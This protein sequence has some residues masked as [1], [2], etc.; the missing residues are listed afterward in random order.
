MRRAV[1]TLS[2]ALMTIA[3]TAALA[4]EITRQT[5]A[6]PEDAYPHDVAA[7]PNGVVWYSGQRLGVLGRLD[8]ATGTVEQIPLG[9]G[10][11]P[12]GV[13]VGP[14]G[15]PWLTD[16]GVNAIVRVDPATRRIDRFPLPEAR[17]YV[18]L[19]TAVFDRSG[20]LW[21]TGQ[22]GVY[23]RLDPTT[24]KVKVWDAPKGRG[25]YGIA[26]TPDGGV[27]FVSLANNYLAKIDTASGAATVIEPPTKD[28][29]ARRVWSDSQ[30]R[31]WISEWSSG[32]LSRYD[33]KTQAWQSWRP[34][35]DRPRLY[36]IYVDEHDIV[37]TSDWGGH[38]ILR[39]DPASEQF[40]SFPLDRGADV[41]Q[42]LGRKGEVWIA[43]SGKD[44]VTVLRF[45]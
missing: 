19:N 10:S 22:N 6:L 26:A 31:L 36:A 42:M 2:T 24:R 15:A 1:L 40:Q 21:F 39:F 3:T 11:A 13:I 41:R 28:Q 45:E 33:P 5:Y 16:G 29:G 14:D 30:S 8:P 32:N 7:G 25:A 27:Y 4:G 44:R 9:K 38:A 43:E 23:G 37:W 35:G 17:G 20:I 12:H 18:N 34:P